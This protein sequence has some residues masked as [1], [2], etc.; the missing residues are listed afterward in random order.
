MNISGKK[1]TV[2]KWRYPAPEAQKN[3]SV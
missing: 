2:E 3:I 1:S